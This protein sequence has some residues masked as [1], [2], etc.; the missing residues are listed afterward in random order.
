MFIDM[1]AHFFPESIAFKVTHQ[2]A[3]Y[4]EVDV[5][6][7]GTLEEYQNLIQRQGVDAAV[8][9]TVATV[10][11]Q[12]KIA[13]DWAIRNT[14]GPL[15]GFGTL[16]PD[17]QDIDGEIQKLKRAGIKG[18][19]F[20]PNFQQFYMDDPKA[21][22]M[23]ERIV[24]DFIVLFHVGDTP[25]R[26]DFSSPTRMSRILDLFPGMQVVAAHMGGWQMWDQ[27]L[28]HLVGREV[29]FDTSSSAGF[30]AP[31]KF[32]QMIR[33]HGYRRILLGSDYPISDPLKESQYLDGLNLKDHEYRGILGE[34]ARKLL[35]R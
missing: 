15:I 6:Y 2:L 17:Y 8:F 31:E 14:K 24:S 23:Y 1:H 7:Q 35:S 20:H 19:K 11:A 16:H 28:E 3:D 5:P 32:K 25:F 4:Y 12:V 10:P 34:N 26:K 29:Y 33:E 18:I 27:A 9:F 22:S 21:L 30:L 13:N